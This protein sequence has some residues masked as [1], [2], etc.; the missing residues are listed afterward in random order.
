MTPSAANE[1]AIARSCCD[2][3]SA[4][5]YFFW[6]N[7]NIAAP[8]R[9]MPKYA[10]KGAPD[11]M[12]IL[13][14]TFYGIECKRPRGTDDQREK[15]GRVIRERKLSPFQAEWATKCALAGGRYFVVH[16]LEELKEIGL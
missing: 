3:L 5:G 6:R 2:Y 9:A 13:G 4:R 11:I 15:N 16:S 12:L 1:S 8:G 14:G 10:L 7:N